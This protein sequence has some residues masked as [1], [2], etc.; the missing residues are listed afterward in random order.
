MKGL[1]L[2][3]WRTQSAKGAAMMAKKNKTYEIL[4]RADHDLITGE[5]KNTYRTLTAEEYKN[6]QEKVL[7]PFAWAIFDQ[8]ATDIYNQEKGLITN[9]PDQNKIL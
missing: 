6:Y 9:E 5:S 1:P 4:V 8:V 7:K 2:W 3:D